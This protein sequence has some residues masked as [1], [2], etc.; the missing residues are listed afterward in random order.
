MGVRAGV[1]SPTVAGADFAL[2]GTIGTFAY[3]LPL[4][5][6]ISSAIL[7]SPEFSFTPSQDPF[8]LEFAFDSVPALS[9]PLWPQD[10]PS[11]FLGSDVTFFKDLLSDGSMELSVSCFS[12]SCPD[13][14]KMTAGDLWTLRIG[15]SVTE[16]PEPSTVLLAFIGMV[17]ILLGRCPVMVDS[18]AS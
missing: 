7:L 10:P 9:L 2:P 12:G 3:T 1:L 8:I 13:A 6:E 11:F 16:I 5:S 15:F 14:Y 17:L 18:V 4:G